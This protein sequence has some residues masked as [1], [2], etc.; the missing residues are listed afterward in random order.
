MVG[1]DI[2]FIHER[3]SGSNPLPLLIPHGWR[4]TFYK[5]LDLIPYLTHPEKIG[6]DPEDSFD[7]I[8]SSIPVAG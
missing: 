6:D 4:S 5:I 2:H 7:V 3:G 8:I 1:M